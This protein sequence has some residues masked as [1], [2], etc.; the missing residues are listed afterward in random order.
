VIT[1][2][3]SPA[4]AAADRVA[5]VIGNAQYEN[6]AVLG[7]TISD[8]T[9]IGS[10]FERLGF[11]VTLQRDQNISALR[12]ALGAFRR[13]AASAE[14]AVVFYAG[15]GIEVDNTN[16]LIPTDAQLKTDADIEFETIPLDLVMRA[17]EGASRLKLVLLDACRDNPFARS[18]TRA[19]AT[20]SIGRGLARVEPSA[21]TLVA[22]A[23]REG[24]TASDGISGE[25][26]P[27]TQALLKYLEEPNLEINLL[28]R[29]VRDAVLSATDGTQ[30]PF[31]YGSLSSREFYFVNTDSQGGSEDVAE[32]LPGVSAED[33]LWAAVE[34]S[35]TFGAF[36]TYLAQFPNGK[37]SAAA[38]VWVD[39][40]KPNGSNN[41]QSQT[42]QGAVSPSGGEIDVASVAV[43]DDFATENPPILECDRLAA[44]PS[45]PSRVT[46]GVEWKDI[47]TN[48]AIAA[49][50]RDAGEFPK[51]DRLKF[52]LAR[53]LHRDEQHG[54][55]AKIYEELSEKS[56][57]AAAVNLGTM[58]LLGQDVE[59]DIAKARRFF[60][61]GADAGNANALYQLGR[62]YK[63]GNG[64]SVDYPRAF[65]FYNRAVEASD[66]LG[67]MVQIGF[68]Y[69]NGLGVTADQKQAFDYYKRAADQNH[70]AAL[71]NVGLMYLTGR[72]VKQNTASAVS[73]LEK[74]AK[75]DFA[76]AMYNL[77]V[78]YGRGQGI[79]RDMDRA[80]HWMFEAIR[81]GHEKA[82]RAMT[83]Q[84]GSTTR[85]FRRLLQS[86]LRDAG[87]YRGTIDGQF[88]P[89]TERAILAL[90]ES[91]AG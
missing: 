27:Y 11:E 53:V 35:G 18:M 80:T 26:S 46:L 70:P 44:D 64:V 1:I 22:F 65:E 21:E 62:M 8:A 56:Y 6:A 16:Y 41:A 49:C 76:E 60:E 14:V 66:H 86:R 40:L 38:Q 2:A 83:T 69:T 51:S 48:S 39:V 33:A 91:D 47:D 36:E 7:N 32:P 68:M 10:T 42:D 67:A 50:R 17:V 15:H 52:Q 78:V 82:I 23:A 89:A 55:A 13:K 29:K 71:N 77:A 75:E 3:T 19:S 79:G 45:D 37:Y 28:F 73:W 34:R 31:T 43:D 54:E 63:E 84:A 90:S 25:H 12:Q 24:T 59:Q 85:E 5:L 87:Y 74:S 61:I 30:E 20:R 58:Y 81:N 88:G 57:T 72:A 4:Q 9:A